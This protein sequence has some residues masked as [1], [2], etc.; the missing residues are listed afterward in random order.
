MLNNEVVKTLGSI[1]NKSLKGV[2]KRRL[3][4]SV[5]DSPLSFVLDE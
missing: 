5:H 2:H 3:M 4:R 1:F